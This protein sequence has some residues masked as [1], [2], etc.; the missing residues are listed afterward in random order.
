VVLETSNIGEVWVVGV[1]PGEPEYVTLKAVKLIDGADYV[2]GFK[3]ALQVVERLVKGKILIIDYANENEVL[4]S[5]ASEAKAGKKCAICC[6]GDP[7]FSDKQFVEKIKSVYM[8]VKVVPG[9]SSVQVSC[10]KA[11]LA[12]EESMF[13]TFHK[14][15]PINNEKEEL[16]RVVKEGHR[17]A[18]VLPRP[19]DFMPKDIAKFLI[20]ND[21]AKNLEVAVHE[22][23]T[24]SNEIVHVCKLSDLLNTEQSDLSIIVIKKR[25][26]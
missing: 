1:G 20:D 5:L 15:G 18:I 8:D 14:S 6:Y 19:W 22:N 21:V 2:A 7:N 25:R 23:L 4:K 16:L 10:A 12:M 17:N 9:I 26:A 11:G 24:L 13:I 3:Q